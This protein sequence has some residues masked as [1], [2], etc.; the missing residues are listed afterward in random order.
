MPTPVAAAVGD[1]GD[2][3][4]RAPAAAPDVADAVVEEVFVRGFDGRVVDV[5]IGV[6]VGGYACGCAGEFCC[7]C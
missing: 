7:C 4:R 3:A 5:A 1:F 6:V 2:V